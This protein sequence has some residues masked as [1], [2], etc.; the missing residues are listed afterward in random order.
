[1][2]AFVES[3]RTQGIH[4]IVNRPK[5]EHW[6]LQ[7]FQPAPENMSPMT[8]DR[9]LA[10]HLKAHNLPEYTKPGSPSFYAAIHQLYDKATTHCTASNHSSYELPCM[11]HLVQLIH[12]HQM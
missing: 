4:V 12:E 2:R 7:H 1:M 5:I 10:H 8:I 6:F 3:A 11:C 9:R